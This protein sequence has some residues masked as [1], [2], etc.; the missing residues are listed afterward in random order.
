[1]TS[2][3]RRR[4]RTSSSD[5]ARDGEFR[6]FPGFVQVDI[7]ATRPPIFAGIMGRDEWAVGSKAVA[8]YQPGVTY[9]FGMIALNET[10]CKAIHIS[11]TGT[12]NAAGNVQAN[13]DGSECTSGP[14]Y[15]FSRTGARR[16]QRHRA[17]CDLPERRPDSGCGQSGR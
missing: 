13:S 14:A 16:P 7:A 4:A 17:G 9:S 5:P 2:T 12:V 3:M 11:G 8:A 1:M 15:G 10:A 6:G